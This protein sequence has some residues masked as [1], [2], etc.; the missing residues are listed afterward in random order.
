MI[1]QKE[2]HMLDYNVIQDKIFNKF[3]DR[4]CLKEIISD[5]KLLCYCNK[6]Q[7]EFE[8]SYPYIFRDKCKDACPLCHGLWNHDSVTNK[9]KEIYGDKITLKTDWIFGTTTVYDKLI[10]NCKYHGDFTNCFAHILHYEHACP[11]C[12]S[13]ARKKAKYKKPI[14]DLKKITDRLGITFNE[15]DYSNANTPICFYKNGEY[16]CK[17]RPGKVLYCDDPERVLLYSRES[18]GEFFIKQL[19]ENNNISFEREKPLKICCILEN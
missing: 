2:L 17:K 18:R 19:L 3:N 16:L 7:H 8:I 9:I 6:H 15:D 13:I 14:A 11:E 5:T 10:F 1:T 4:I 12:I